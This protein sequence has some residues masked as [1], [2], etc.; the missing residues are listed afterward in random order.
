ML[1]PFVLGLTLGGVAL[2]FIIHAL[3]PRWPDAPPKAEAPHLPVIIAG[4]TFQVPPAAIRNAVQR[5]P[6]PQDRIDLVY[7]WSALTPS[8]PMPDSAAGSVLPSDRLFVSIAPNDGVAHPMERLRTT[9]PRYTAGDRSPAPAGLAM[10]AFRDDTPYRGEDLIYDERT[11]EHFAARCSRPA[12]ALTPATCLFE[13][14]V[15]AANITVRFP[16]AWLADWRTLAEKLD[17]LIAELHAN[18]AR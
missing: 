18:T 10:V 2:G 11:P 17:R 15:G 16:R 14:F 7:T 9:Y 6:G 1:L 13:R 3:W 4:E 8:R 5:H 12:S